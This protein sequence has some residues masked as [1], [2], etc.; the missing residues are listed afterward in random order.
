MGPDPVPQPGPAK[1]T[2]NSTIDEWLQCALQ[3]QYLPEAIIK[4]LCEMCK[5]LLMEGTLSPYRSCY[6]ITSISKLKPFIRIKHTASINTCH[7]LW[8]FTR[9]ILR[10]ARALSNSRRDTV[11][12]KNTRRTF[13]S[14]SNKRNHSSRYRAPVRDHGSESQEENEKSGQIE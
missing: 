4:K 3:N 9:S 12:C 2:K 8:R 10:C 14:T 7:C 6:T 5:E 13:A 11:G 1:L